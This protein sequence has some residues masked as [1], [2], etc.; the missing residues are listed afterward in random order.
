MSSTEIVRSFFAAVY[1]ADYERAFRDYAHPGFAWVVGSA[2]NDGLRAAI[3]WAGYELVGREGY[4]A[5]TSMLFS[6]F[7]PLSFETRRYVA[8][9]DLVFVEGHFTFGH[10]Q[11]GKIADSDWLARFDMRDGRIAGGQFYEN[12]YAVAAARR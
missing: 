9:G 12:T 6:E 8:A 7:E 10:R 4:V 1:A 5:L 2:A 11:T 3:P